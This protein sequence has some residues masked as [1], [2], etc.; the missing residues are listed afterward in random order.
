MQTLLYLNID[1]KQ[2]AGRPQVRNEP[3]H[4][5]TQSLG[6]AREQRQGVGRLQDDDCLVCDTPAVEVWNCSDRFIPW[7]VPGRWRL[8]QHRPAARYE[9]QHAYRELPFC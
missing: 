4:A 3:D 6:L 1:G 8:A 2:D 7:L 9:V 5:I